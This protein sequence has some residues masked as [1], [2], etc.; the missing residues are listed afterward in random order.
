[1]K[2]IMKIK[3]NNLKR[4][5]FTGLLC[6][7]FA[8]IVP[9][10]AHATEVS[11]NCGA[12]G[13]GSNVHWS[14]DTE[15]KTLTISGSGKMV[16]Y[17]LPSDCP[18]NA[19]KKYYASEQA[20][21]ITVGENVTNIGSCSFRRY[22][23][24]PECTISIPSSVTE[25]GESALKG[26]KISNTSNI[27]WSSIETIGKDAFEAVTFPTGTGLTFDGSSSL[28]LIDS[29]A[30]K[31]SVNLTSVTISKPNVSI[32]S[33]AFEGNINLTSVT[34]TGDY[35]SIGDNAFRYAENINSPITSI[36][37]GGRETTVGESAF[38][39]E[40]DRS[41]FVS[42]LTLLEGITKIGADAF[43]FNRYMDT[44]VTTLILPTTLTHIGS[45]AFNSM[46]KLETLYIL[47]EGRQL[48]NILNTVNPNATIIHAASTNV[49]D[50]DVDRVEYT[51]DGDSVSVTAIDGT[52]GTT[53]SVNVPASIPKSADASDGSYSITAVLHK[54]GVSVNNAPGGAA[55]ITYKKE[56]DGTITITD[57][58]K[59]SSSDITIPAT[60]QGKKI[61]KVEVVPEGVTLKHTHYYKNGVCT[62][63]GI[64]QAQAPGDNNYSVSDDTDTS[65]D[66]SVEEALSFQYPAGKNSARIVRTSQ[67][68]VCVA[69]F[70]AATPTAY[71]EAFSFNLLID[72]K[73]GYEKKQGTLT[74][75][76]PTKYQ[77]SGRTF[78]IIGVS[79]QGKPQVFAD[80]D[81]NANTITINVEGFEGYAFSLIYTDTAAAL[82]AGNSSTAKSAGI[83]GSLGSDS[84]GSYYIVQKGD[85]LS[86]IAVMLGKKRQ[87]L[88]D[89]NQM[90]D[91][92]KLK[93]GQKIY[94]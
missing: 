28:T 5:L 43:N 91:P 18:W 2:E 68:P 78:G 93:I 20:T 40:T 37:I 77:K 1:M 29:R 59:G 46:G 57:I 75:S 13:D 69:A 87:A 4:L 65:S 31:D 51:R 48:T 38:F 6:L 44:T 24:A 84:K 39:V 58:K 15:S 70:A 62:I 3:A 76:I 53:G 25:I 23:E 8:G 22:P 79:K 86:R 71:T 10:S 17:A 41:A 30:F 11:G 66:T 45:N 27:N 90:D 54:E 60:I 85:V 64:K 34:I 52:E 9:V 73:A 33:S 47:G 49:S 21:R 67:G 32:E 42:S 83:A 35:T 80:T 36:T 89:K 7:V 14:Y 19:D 82:R 74:I 16:D 61:A 88:I 56:A 55:D 63:C 26:C 94:Y 72:N 92:N 81:A 12:E 50:M